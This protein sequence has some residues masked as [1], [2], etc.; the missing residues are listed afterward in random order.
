MHSQ[1][2]PKSYRGRFAPSPSGSLHFGSLI[3]ATASYLDA[4]A[5]QGKWLLRIEDVDT[6]RVRSGA[7]QSILNILEVYGFEWDEDVLYQSQR[8]EAYQ[9]ELNRLIDSQLVY[10]CS[11]SRKSLNK[12]AKFGASG[13]IYPNL[14]RKELY[15]SESSLRTYRLLT[16]DRPISFIDRIEGLQTQCIES[17]VGDFALK[18]SDGIFTYQLAVVVD[19][20]YQG[21][22]D[23]VRGK[24][25]LD[26]T[27][28]QL[29]LQQLLGYST[30]RYL[31]F[32]TML[33]QS[34]KKLSKQNHAPEIQKEDRLFNIHKCLQF[35]GQKPPPIDDFDSVE[36]LWRW[37]IANW[38]Y[39]K[40]L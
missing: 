3:A 29:Y 18:R 12:I 25:L 32:P 14:C 13:L 19:D 24:D 34:G 5:H 36:S 37:A 30:P 22:T 27:A 11:C 38:E 8:F 39:K 20:E 1:D 31:H 2:T 33:D 15:N 35:L 6:P 21:I 17:E 40:I 4:K 28:R 7:I 10:P 26:N 9:S 16:D 23:V